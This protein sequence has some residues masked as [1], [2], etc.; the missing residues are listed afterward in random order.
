MNAPVK[1]NPQTILRRGF[2]LVE[3][4]VVITII[5]IL[6]GLALPAIR[7][8]I[9]TSSVTAIRLEMESLS[10]ATERYQQ[11]YGDYPP[12]FSN[13]AVVQRH[14]RKLFPRMAANEMLLLQNMTHVSGVFNPVAIDR[15]EAIV[16]TLGAYSEDV[17]H[18]FTG[19]GGPLAWVGNGSDSY[20]APAG[21]SNP[22]QVNAAQ[23]NPVN[24]QINSDRVN[25]LHD[26]DP[27]R[28][29]L[30]SV[31][32]SAALTG[33]NKYTSTD[34]GDLVLTYASVTEGGPFVY[35]DSRTYAH[36]DPNIN[37]GVGDF[38]GYGSTDFGGV[39]P[40]ISTEAV[41][42]PS[43][44]NYA[45]D[46]AAVNAWRFVNSDTFQLVAPGLDGSFGNVVSFNV[47]SDTYAEP[48]YFQ[49]PT[50][51][52]AAPRT[53]VGTPGQLLITGVN[54]FQE[55]GF[56]NQI[57]SAQLDNIASFAKAKLV[58]DVKQ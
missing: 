20:A 49:Y 57:E 58:D 11:K 34:D 18:P 53:D 4:L 44:A 2:T 7:T 19:P 50:G 42:N 21:A 25:S 45:T 55:T 56:P 16:W 35:F 29:S 48:V 27:G 22:T 15:A 1:P 43:G 23:Q 46:I 32:A 30:S 26:F 9:E 37:G 51:Q 8:A 41:A 40:Y 31:N 17:Q 14:Y 13:W 54:G 47:D 36:F 3:L 10:S 39:R 28:L 24:Y 6:V 12:D 52:A 5:G 38:N 33:A